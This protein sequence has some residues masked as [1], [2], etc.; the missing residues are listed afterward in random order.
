MK[1]YS[2]AQAGLQWHNLSSLPGGKLHLLGSSDS[3][4]SASSGWDYRR[5]PRCP[6]NFCTFSK[7]GVSPCLSG[8]SGTPDLRW[9]AHLSL[10][11]YWDYRHE[12]PYPAYYKH[13]YNIFPVVYSDAYVHSLEYLPR[14]EML[15][16][17]I[18]TSSKL[19]GN[20]RPLPKYLYQF[21]LPPAVSLLH[22][23]DNT[24]GTIWPYFL[25]IPVSMTW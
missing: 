17:L 19:L 2:V 1:S 10:P 24:Y 20:I 3:P 4:S 16:H 5:I 21:T 14:N 11:K 12:P 6:A 7:G 25:A 23:L 9:S 8:W 15:G 13:S 18:C 22:I